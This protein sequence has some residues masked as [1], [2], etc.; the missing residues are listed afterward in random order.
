M[1]LMI[2]DLLSV[3]TWSALFL[4]GEV[5]LLADSDGDGF[6]ELSEYVLGTDPS[7]AK[8]R[9]TF[10]LIARDEGFI[11]TFGRLPNRPDATL[12]IEGSSDLENWEV[13]EVI[14]VAEGFE[15]IPRTQK[16]Y[17]RLKFSLN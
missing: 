16:S 8:D 15:I 3:D 2:S 7:L 9:P 5:N 11:W 4:G 10:E 13:V 1:P 6:N 17:F 12:K 14:R